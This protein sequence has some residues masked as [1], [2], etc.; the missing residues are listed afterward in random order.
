M[1]T[2]IQTSDNKEPFKLE[3]GISPNR[4]V[5]ICWGARAI[6]NR[7]GEC[8]LLGDRQDCKGGTPE[9]CKE[10]GKWL[11]EYGIPAIK[12]LTRDEY[13]EPREDR[14]VSICLHQWFIVVNP[15]SSYGYLYIGVY[16]VDTGDPSFVPAPV[17]SP[18]PPKPA[19]VRKTRTSTLRK[20]K[21]SFY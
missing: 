1:T 17:P 14:A 7:P 9:Q 8:D 12:K 13:L 3:W 19:K 18:P 6:Y 20:K 15:R 5:S 2:D 11:N 4:E 10:F 16:P 21:N